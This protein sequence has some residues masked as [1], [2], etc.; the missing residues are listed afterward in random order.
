LSSNYAQQI[1]VALFTFK[2]LKIN[3]TT[4]INIFYFFFK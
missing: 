4:C 2:I 1:R 3:K